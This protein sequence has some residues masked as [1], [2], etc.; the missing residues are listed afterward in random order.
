MAIIF[1]VQ[2]E[3]KAKRAMADKV[4]FDLNYIIDNQKYNYYY[5]LTIPY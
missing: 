4:A 1:K 2:L 5:V 3:S